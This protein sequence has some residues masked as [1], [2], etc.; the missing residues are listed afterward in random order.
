MAKDNNPGNVFS[1]LETWLR[2]HRRRF[3]ASLNPGATPAELDTLQKQVAAPLPEFLRTLLAWHNGQ[4][5]DFVGAFE[6][7]WLL[8]SCQ[9]IAEAKRYLDA[10][11]KDMGWQP[12]WIPFLDND[13]GDYLCADTSQQ[14]APVRA[15]YLG[16]TEHPAVAESLER[17]VEDFVSN[18]EKGN[19][20]EEPERG[21]FM[22]SS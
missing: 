17:W 21:T 16:N 4:G 18:V 2:K 14:Q 20:V 13:A 15:F 7:N 12:A 6:E 8:M 1:R 11:A 5:Q 22:K 19:Y 10:E 9:T 3:L